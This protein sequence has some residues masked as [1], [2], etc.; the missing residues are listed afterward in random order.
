M[1]NQQ[2]NAVKHPAD[3]Q[4]REQVELESWQREAGRDRALRGKWEK[5]AT[6]TL[7]QRLAIFYVDQVIKQ[8]EKAREMPGRNAHIWALMPGRKAVEH[9]ALESLCYVLGSNDG[10]RPFNQLAVSLGQRA[11]YVLFL[12]HPRW[13]RSYHLEGL[14]LASNC[15]LGMRW[16]VN[17]LRQHG[18]DEYRPLSHA[19][20][21][22]LGALFLEIMAMATKMIEINTV[23][24]ARNRKA[25]MVSFT[26]LY[27]SFLDRWKDAAG[28]FRPIHMPMVSGPRPWT[29]FADGGYMTIRTGLSTVDWERW[30]ELSKRAKPCVVGSVNY[31]QDQA[32]QVDHAQLSL[33]ENVW[34]LGHEIG[35]LP[36]QRRAEPPSEEKGNPDYWPQLFAFKASQRRDVD[37]TRMVH[38]FVSLRRLELAD[39]LHWVHFM[40]HRGR[41]YPRGSQLNVQGPDH[42]RS[43]ISF[44]EQSPVKGHERQFAWSFGEALG[45]P[46]DEAERVRYLETMSTVVGQVG[47][48]PLSNLG[49]WI[50]AKSPWR[51]IQL[52]RDWHEYLQD[53]GYTSGTIHWRDQTCSG[54]GHVACLTGDAQLAR[55]TNVVGSNP[56]DLYTGLG[57]VVDARI[58]WLNENLTEDDKRPSELRCLAWWRKHQIPRSLWK[59]ALMPVIYG[60]SYQSLSDGIKEYLRDEVQ[61]F[62]ADDNLRIVELANVL[63]TAIND[64]VNEAVPHARDLARWLGVIAGMQID[65]GKRPYWFTP[66]GLAVESWC[67]ET[68]RRSVRLD[69]A[70]T[71]INVCVRD[72]TGQKPDKARSSRK[73]VPDYIHSMDAAFLQ[74]FVAHWQAFNHP[75]ATVHDCFGTT[76]QHVGTMRQEL[77]DQWH[78][79]YSTDW[80]TR[81]QGM[82]EMVLGREV[83]APPIVGTLDRSQIGENPFLFT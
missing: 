7:S 30:P 43:L 65:A 1:T 26:T 45:S 48:E 23:V 9:V 51:L 49:F 35:S 38:A 11:E 52:C 18:G 53:P 6:N 72:A 16:V 47:S 78:R 14:R 13:R 10:P 33:L 17:R 82:A 28:M 36:T 76:L 5:G 46:P 75:I 62:L 71:T 22:A 3:E 37:R 24:V 58:R 64:V 57:R 42:I 50:N 12:L 21:A 15:D 66:N 80:L 54:W 29:G 4:P 63:A 74:R 81:H 19:E 61:D 55:F 31:L 8:W 40:D 67:S 39:R 41:V 83:P 69:L 68:E 20:R 34:H 44:D 25:R 2:S 70:R 73:L 77:N 56:A 27:W 32:F 59:K 60:R 79:F